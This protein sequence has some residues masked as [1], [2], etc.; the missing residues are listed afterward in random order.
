[1]SGTIPKLDLFFGT[2]WPWLTTLTTIS[3]SIFHPILSVSYCPDVA[4]LHSWLQMGKVRE[5][6]L[7]QPRLTSFPLPSFPWKTAGSKASLCCIITPCIFSSQVEFLAQCVQSLWDQHGLNSTWKHNCISFSIPILTRGWTPT[8]AAEERQPHRKGCWQR[9]QALTF[10][11]GM[12][13]HHTWVLVLNT[14]VYSRGQLR[15]G[16]L[17]S[18]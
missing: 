13:I 14:N 4:N 2:A 6:C 3:N 1:M 17:C 9:C 11:F 10:F 12:V 5:S 7:A 16:F 18:D 15:L 8:T